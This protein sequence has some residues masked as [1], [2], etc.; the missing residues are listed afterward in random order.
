MFSLTPKSTN[1][2]KNQRGWGTAKPLGICASAKMV[3]C[4]YSR[5]TLSCRL[6]K[7]MLDKGNRGIDIILKVDFN[8][9][10]SSP[11]K[12]YETVMC[13]T[14][15]GFSSNI[16]W[17]NRYHISGLLWGTHSQICIY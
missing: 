4:F 12:Y 11:G 15:L 2:S 10:P 17:K 14:M 9:G 1:K 7:D 13:Y 5:P 3:H 6:V 8:V 16:F